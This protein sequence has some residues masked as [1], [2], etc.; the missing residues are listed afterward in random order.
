MQLDKKPVYRKIIVPWYDSLTS[1]LITVLIM[2]VVLLLGL[3]GVSAAMR[4][5]E[6][7][8]HIWVP[9]LFVIS[10]GSVI[11]SVTVR[12]VTRYTGSR[13]NSFHRFKFMNSEN[14]GKKRDRRVR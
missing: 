1:C 4:N 5:P 13:Q 9:S 12:L 2:A 11:L 14:S 3:A 10:G 6:Y 8:R 7:Q